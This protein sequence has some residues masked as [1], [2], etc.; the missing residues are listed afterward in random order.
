MPF[1]LEVLFRKI[2]DNFDQEIL[3]QGDLS[4]YPLFPILLANLLWHRRSLCNFPIS[5]FLPE[6]FEQVG[7]KCVL[8]NTINAADFHDDNI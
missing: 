8:C 7:H 4:F 6:R 3:E 2:L 5:N 1:L